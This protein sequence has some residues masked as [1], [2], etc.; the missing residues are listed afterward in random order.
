MN[1]ETT[2]YIQERSDKYGNVWYVIMEKFPYLSGWGIDEYNG[3]KY[4]DKLEAESK[5]RAIISS[6]KL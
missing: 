3:D 2:Y 5:L 6:Q 1:K 4:E